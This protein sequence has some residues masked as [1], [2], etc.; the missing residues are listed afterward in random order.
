MDKKNIK[1]RKIEEN[2]LEILSSF[3]SLHAQPSYSKSDY[4]RRFDFWWH[5][6]PAFRQNDDM[7]WVI[8]D[9]EEANYIK[10]FLGNIPADYDILGKFYKT[11]SPSTWVVA[12]KYKTHS[13]KLLFL[14][15][16]QDKDILINSTPGA[17]TERIFLKLGF[18]DIAKNQNNYVYLKSYKPIKYFL[19][20]IFFAKKLNLKLSKFI[21][22]I[23]KYFFTSSITKKISLEKITNY[24]EIKILIKN[25]IISLNN[26]NWVL[27][28][29]QNKFFYKI[30]TKTSKEDI[31][32]GQYFYNPINKL[33]FFQILF[34]SLKPSLDLIHIV[35][36]IEGDIKSTSDLIIL[37]NCNYSSILINRFIKYN[38]SSPSKCLIKT[39]DS[40]LNEL[41]PDG[42]LGEKGFILWD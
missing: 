1:I 10:G 32:Y 11:A 41:K 9:T 4:M 27:K 33:R 7:G 20:K 17:V 30:K 28:N 16:K 42:S 25:N 14:F 35:E 13:L 36:K 15:L 24:E 23:Y 38:L 31:L 34:T 12:E 5:S 40:L 8:V 22:S 21:F 39:S 6:N 2:D 18:T 29:D 26:F 3:L 37:P 19:N